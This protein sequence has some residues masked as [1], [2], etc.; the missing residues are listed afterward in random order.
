[1]VLN[2]IENRDT[3]SYR[4]NVKVHN[5]ALSLNFFPPSIRPIATIGTETSLRIAF[6]VSFDE[7]GDGGGGET[8]SGVEGPGAWTQQS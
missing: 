2:L 6:I 7:L 1:M 3:T 5:L 4:T 8:K